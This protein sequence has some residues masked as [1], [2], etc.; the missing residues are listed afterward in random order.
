MQK[1]EYN[2][3]K[4]NELPISVFYKQILSNEL[5]VLYDYFKMNEKMEIFENW[6]IRS[7]AY[8]VKT[9]D[10]FKVLLPENV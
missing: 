5:K 3:T 10:G 9:T 4:E 7:N 1:K 8:I 2:E 6:I